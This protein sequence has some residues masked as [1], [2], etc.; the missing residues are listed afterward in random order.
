MGISEKTI[1]KPASKTYTI[2][3]QLLAEMMAEVVSLRNTVVEL[4]HH[5]IGVGVG[6]GHTSPCSKELC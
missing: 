4:Q 2:D 1:T 3:E 6:E 5:L